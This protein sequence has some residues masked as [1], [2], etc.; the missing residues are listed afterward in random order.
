[1]LKYLL[2]TTSTCPRCP[3]MKKWVK[4]LDFEG[5]VLNER[6]ENFKKLATQYSVNIA[7]L[8][9]ILKQK[10]GKPD[11]EIARFTEIEDIKDWLKLANRLR[12]KKKEENGEKEEETKKGKPLKFKSAAEL[13]KAI[14]DYF[15]SCYKKVRDEDG[16]ESLQL[17]KPFT[18]CGL[19]MQLGCS[20][21]TL[22]NYSKKEEFGEVIAKAKLTMERWLEEG[23]AENTQGKIF[24]LKNNYGWG[25]RTE[26]TGKDGGPIQTTGTLVYLPMRQGEDM[27]YTGEITPEPE[28]E[29]PSQHN[30]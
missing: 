7:P 25:D 21:Q 14:D 15:N 23:I 20:R 5:T 3:E 4:K 9:L 12:D 29:A 2:F 16:K 24:S 6:D 28:P 30:S 19:A 22:V 10:E 27:K 11:K 13:Q 18:M 1:M 26:L 17:V 8:L